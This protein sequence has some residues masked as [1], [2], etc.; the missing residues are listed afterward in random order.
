MKFKVQG[1]SGC[2]IKI[3]DH[4]KGLRVIKS[5]EKKKYIPRLEKQAQKQIDFFR[6]RS[7]NILTPE[8]YQTN[9]TDERFSIEME[10]I[11]SQNFIEF[12]DFENV[13]RL[14]AFSNQIINFIKS[15][16]S[17]CKDQHI[18]ASVLKFKLEDISENLKKSSL[19]NKDSVFSEALLT[20]FELVEKSKEMVLPV[21]CC[22]GDLTMSN[23]LFSGNNIY[24]IDFLDSF[25]ETPLMDIVKLRQDTKYIWSF[26]MLEGRIDKTRLEIIL[27][28]LDKKIDK[29][30]SSFGFYSEHYKL[31]Q[32]INFLR[33]LQY[34][35]SEEIVSFIKDVLIKILES[36]DQ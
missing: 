29:E 13:Q 10:L 25:V 24:L 18:P 1:H 9:K 5:T 19:T 30:F 4:G 23:M 20:S 33:I 14:Q 6:K 22:H 15:E 16:I 32:L 2:E 28:F 12:F 3:I 11:Y 17:E 21:G 34:A 27:S 31:F 7:E 36:H 26:N 35:R 8:I